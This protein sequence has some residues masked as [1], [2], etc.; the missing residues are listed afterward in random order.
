MMKTMLGLF[1]VLALCSAAVV[2][3]SQVRPGAV[4]AGE[5]IAARV[6]ENQVYVPVTVNGQERLW[7]LDCGAGASVIDRG[8]AQNLGLVE[9]GEAEGLGAAGSVKLGLVTVPKFRVGNIELDSQQMMTMG[10]TE[11]VRR[12]TG[13]APAGILGYSFF[14]QFVTRV[15][16]AREEVTLFRPEGFSYKGPGRAIPMAIEDN[17]PVVKMLVDGKYRG[18]WRLDLGAA[19][20]VFH[21]HAVKEFGLA[22]R[23]GV[24]RLAIGAGGMERHRLV[25]FAKAELAGFEVKRPVIS[26]PLEGGGGALAATSVVGTLGNTILRNFTVYLDYRQ[27]RAILERGGNFGKLLVLDRSGLGV[28]EQEDGS[29][30]VIHAAPGTPADSAGFKAGD[31]I[32]SV[33]GE[34]SAGLGGIGRLRELLRAAPGT[35][36]AV[37]VRRGDDSLN[38]SLVLADIL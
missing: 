31:I 12:H 29:F 33:N 7:L 17:I 11:L 10:V 1:F 36:Y 21:R 19:A 5:R 14:A 30:E 28:A 38:L 9:S 27:N 35:R 3:P 24:E 2:Q 4:A 8:F 26:V 13:A 25:R 32:E 34:S 6:I 23:S 22:A 20:A 18:R 16:F 15:D 37:G